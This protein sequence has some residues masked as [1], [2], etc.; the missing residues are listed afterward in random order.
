MS[1]L[2]ES[3]AKIARIGRNVGEFKRNVGKVVIFLDTFEYDDVKDV[4]SYEVRA[5][6]SC[7][8]EV[9]SLEKNQNLKK[10]KKLEN[11]K[12]FINVTE[13]FIICQCEI[14]S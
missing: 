7:F 4:P 11:K 5:L 8:I 14:T 12:T 3:I 2:S 6:H 13:K 9:K 1:T 10:V